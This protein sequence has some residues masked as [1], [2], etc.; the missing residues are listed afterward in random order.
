MRPVLEYNTTLGWTIT[1]QG[2]KIVNTEY[3]VKNAD[4]KKLIVSPSL[5]V[6][7]TME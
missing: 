3:N 6:P 1:K 7:L 5:Y 4:G 2:G